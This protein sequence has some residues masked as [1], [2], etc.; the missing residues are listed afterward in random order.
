LRDYWAPS[1]FPK[2]KLGH[3]PKVCSICP[4]LVNLGI[5]KVGPAG[6]GNIMRGCTKYELGVKALAAMV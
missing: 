6:I 2:I 3:Y 5:I 1:Y 4:A